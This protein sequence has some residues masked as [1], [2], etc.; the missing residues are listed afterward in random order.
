VLVV[1]VVEVRTCEEARER[2]RMEHAAEWSMQQNVTELSG[3][4]HAA[5][6]S[7]MEQNGAEWT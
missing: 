2:S 7:R 4:E 6:W 5:E 1:C 3:M